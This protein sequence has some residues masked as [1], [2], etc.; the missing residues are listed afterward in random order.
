MSL[1]LY[2]GGISWCSDN[3]ESACNTGD[4]VRSLGR[5][6]ALEKEMATYSSILAWK[7]PWMEEPGGLPYIGSQRARH[8]SAFN[9]KV[10]S[11][12]ADETIL[13][14]LEYRKSVSFFY[15]QWLIVICV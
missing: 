7:I 8:D 6:D 9:F 5:E 2:Y 11:V 4:L 15:A 3:K 12:A 14:N 1:S 13:R 10:V